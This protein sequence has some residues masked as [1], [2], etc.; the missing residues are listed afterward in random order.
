MKTIGF[1]R[2]YKKGSSL[3]VSSL[4]AAWIAG[5]ENGAATIANCYETSPA[6]V[7]NY[8]CEKEL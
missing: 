6:E 7:T 2:S 4:Q 1:P 8:R 5:P 3:I